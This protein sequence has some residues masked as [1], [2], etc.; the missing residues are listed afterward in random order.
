MESVSVGITFVHCV[1]GRVH[2]DDDDDDDDDM[3]V[4][5]RFHPLGSYAL[6]RTMTI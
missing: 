3:N 4:S 2:N 5:V 1:F 6:Q